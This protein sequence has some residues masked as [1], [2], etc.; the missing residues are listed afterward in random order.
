MRTLSHLEIVLLIQVQPPQIHSQMTFMESWAKTFCKRLRGELILGKDLPTMEGSL[1]VRMG[2]ASSGEGFVSFCPAWN[3]E[4]FIL[5]C[6]RFSSC[7]EPTSEVAAQ[8][9]SR[10]A[11]NQLFPSGRSVSDEFKGFGYCGQRAH[12]YLVP[13]MARIEEQPCTPGSMWICHRLLFYTHLSLANT[14]VKDKGP[15]WGKWEKQWVSV[16]V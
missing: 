10:M 3:E 8:W 7:S 16:R 9:V 6:F 12:D 15:K 1:E 14:T 2:L 4:S 11:D 13:Q 5:S